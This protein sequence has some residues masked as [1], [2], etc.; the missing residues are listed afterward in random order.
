M[1]VPART[2]PTKPLAIKLL[3]NLTI[4]DPLRL[5]TAFALALI[6]THAAGQAPEA[7]LPELDRIVIQHTRQRADGITRLDTQTIKT[8]EALKAQYLRSANLNG[9]NR[10]QAQIEALKKEINELAP[11]AT[12]PLGAHGDVYTVK[13]NGL[14]GDARSTV[15]NIVRFKVTKTTNRAVVYIDAVK[16]EHSSKGEVFLKFDDKKVPIGTWDQ[17]TMSSSTPRLQFD[18]SAYI[19]KPGEYAVELVWTGARSGLRFTSA[20]IDTRAE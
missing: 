8:L 20:T 7:P 16:P 1:S 13:Q 6:V 17:V 5:A 2:F 10:T 3:T 19:T 14:A 11:S 15:G 18:A 4:C 12:P 9:A